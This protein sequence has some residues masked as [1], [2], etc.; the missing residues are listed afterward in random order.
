MTRLWLLRH[1]QTTGLKTEGG[2]VTTFYSVKKEKEIF[3]KSFL[4]ISKNYSF[5][6]LTLVI[7]PYANS[8]VHLPF[9]AY[10]IKSFHVAMSLH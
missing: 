4:N 8:Y 9:L 6:G 3:L 10:K 5:L 1:Q 7:I 2:L